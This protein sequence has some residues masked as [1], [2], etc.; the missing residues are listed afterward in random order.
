VWGQTEVDS[1]QA[2]AQ[3]WANLNELKPGQKIRVNRTNAESVASRFV[4]VAEEGLVVQVKRGQITVPRSQI[5]EVTEP[6]HGKRL[7]NIL[8][9]LGVGGTIGAVVARG[10]LSSYPRGVPLAAAVFILAG[11]G[12]LGAAMPAERTVYRSA[13]KVSR[14]KR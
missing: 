12:T 6:S 3:P 9:G 4:S 14:S 10:P 2:T 1:H 13:R 11:G 5:T 8:I 7:R